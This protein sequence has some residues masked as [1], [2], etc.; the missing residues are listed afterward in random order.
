MKQALLDNDSNQNFYTYIYHRKKSQ[1]PTS[2]AIIGFEP[3][4][5]GQNFMG[6]RFLDTIYDYLISL[7]SAPVIFI[8]QGV[9]I[10]L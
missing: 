9:Q 1:V 5:M 10:K 3:T 6:C 2:S 8:V 4:Q 7:R